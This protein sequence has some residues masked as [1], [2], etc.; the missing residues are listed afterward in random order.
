M[1]TG[2][3]LVAGALRVI[4]SLSP[5][6]GIPGAEADVCLGVLNSMLAAW[7][8]DSLLPPC[9]TIESFTWTAGQNSYT[10][11]T[12]GSP[13]YSTVRPD[14]VTDAFLR[15]SGANDYSLDVTMTAGE[16]NAVPLKTATGRPQRLFYD[17]QYPNGVIYL[18]CATDQQY[19]LFLESLKPV[20]QFSALASTLVMPGEYQEAI[21][22]LLAERLAP[23]YGF[24]LTPDIQ[25]L[26]TQARK[27][28]YRKNLRPKASWYDPAFAKPPA[29]NVYAG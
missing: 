13:S 2:T 19:T 27:R 29:F 26:I 6:E 4:S 22:Y 25:S 10:V 16:Y 28:L 9:R 1:A 11:G 23:E 18:D 15:D 14:E 12:S 24:A 3:D 5:G 20:N 17:P 7:S 8:A 21:K